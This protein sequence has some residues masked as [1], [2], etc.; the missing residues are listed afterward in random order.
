MASY[1]IMLAIAGLLGVLI[2]A[3]GFASLAAADSVSVP[4]SRGW[5]LAGSPYAGVVGSGDCSALTKWAYVGGGYY[6]VGSPA[7]GS[8]YWV[9]SAQGCSSVF[10]GSPSASQQITLQPGWNIIAIQAQAMP[11]SSL[12]TT[13]NQLPVFF[14]YDPNTGQYFRPDVLEPGTA[15]GLVLRVPAASLL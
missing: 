5:N 11:V 1:D 9:R 8:G 15:T 6:R 10:S 14:G 3:C 13:C 4:L 2:L 12:E 7:P